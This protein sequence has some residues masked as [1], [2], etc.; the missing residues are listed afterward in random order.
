MDAYGDAGNGNFR[1][2]GQE[3]M[4]LK[5]RLTHSASLIKRDMTSERLFISRRNVS[6]CFFD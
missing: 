5:G 1:N 4:S 3:M 2:L 6:K